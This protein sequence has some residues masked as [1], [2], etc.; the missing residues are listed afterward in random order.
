MK[1]RKTYLDL[2]NILACICVIYMH[3]N[4]IVH[5]YSDTIEWKQSMLVETLA[6]WAVPIFFMISGATLLNYRERYDT[7]TYLKKRLVRVG[8]PFI[9]WSMIN[10][11]WKIKAGKLVIEYSVQAVFSAFINSR[12]ENVYWFFIPLFSVYFAIPVLSKLIKERD[13]LRYMIL[14]GFLTYSFLPTIFSILGIEYNVGLNFPI[15][16]GYLLYTLL[17][18][19][20]STEEVTAKKRYFFYGLAILGAIIRYSSTVILSVRQGEIYRMFWGYL[21]FPTV[22]LSIGIF[23]FFRYS[24]WNKLVRNERTIKIVKS[25][26][27]ASFGIY[28][29]HMMVMNYFW[30]LGVDVYG[31]KWRVLGAPLIYCI[32]LLLVKFM[33]KIPIVKKIIP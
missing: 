9:A 28:L 26:S 30:D 3:C 20:L 21:N 13:V 10:L 17:G 32:C 18:Y 7:K 19:Y 15:T 6:Y 5:T 14:F 27:S 25:I 29:L 22:F 16:G 31:L 24:D 8:I 33:Q 12:I 23:L 4:G 11:I 2:L 1:Q